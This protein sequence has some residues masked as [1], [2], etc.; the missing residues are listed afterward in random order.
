MDTKKIIS[1][2]ILGAIL[3]TAWTYTKSTKPAD[4]AARIQITNSFN[5]LSGEVGMAPDEFKKVLD[6]ALGK[7]KEQLRK[8]VVRLT[9]PDGSET[10]GKIVIDGMQELA[11]P[12]QVLEALPISYEKDE[13]KERE[14]E[15]V[16][17]DIIVRAMDMGRPQAGW[18]AVVPDVSDSRLPVIIGDE[19]SPGLIPIGKLQVADFTV[20]WKKAMNGEEKPIRIVL[21]RIHRN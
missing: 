2:C 12:D 8:D 6:D 1:I 20:V 3:W 18:A 15:F 14:R 17:R 10:N 9:H 13:P 16:K 21:H 11:I 5:R 19:I 7:R 4:Q